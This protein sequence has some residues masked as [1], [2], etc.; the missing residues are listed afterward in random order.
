MPITSGDIKYKLSVTTGSAGNTVAQADP[1]AALGKYIST[2]DWNQSVLA[3]N[4]FDLITGDQNAAGAVDYRC[5]FVWNNHATNT[6]YAPK[7]WVSEQ[8]AGG[9][10]VAIGL[11]PAGV[12]PVGQSGAQAA[13]VANEATAPAGVTFSTPLSKPAGLSVADVPAGSCFAV[14]LRRTATDSAAKDADGV[15]IETSGDTAE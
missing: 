8:I 13:T 5:V 14:W 4:L 1:N 6:W 2:S 11:D 15:T 7:V 9:A 12:V 3:G 10:D